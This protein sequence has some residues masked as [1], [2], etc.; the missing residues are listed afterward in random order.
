M[1]PIIIKGDLLECPKGINVIAHQANTDGIMGA[2]IAKAIKTK[3][4]EAYK[5]DREYHIPFGPERLG[6]WSYANVLLH[7]KVIGIINLYGQQLGK[8][9]KYGIPT[10]YDAL[11]QSM[12]RLKIDLDNGYHMSGDTPILG[13]PKGMGCGLGGG[14]WE[15]MVL[16]RIE[17]VFNKSKF[18]VYIV[19][20]K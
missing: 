9:S 20:K 12:I 3:W 8:L 15:G 19:E 11:L 14:D 10:D 16:P 13:L 5:A 2:G 6:W 1:Q 4:P 18:P 7:N 17:A